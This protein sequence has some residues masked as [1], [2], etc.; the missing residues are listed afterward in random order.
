M[1]T[2][3]AKSN[4]NDKVRIQVKKKRPEQDSIFWECY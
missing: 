4:I 1:S 2:I 3:A